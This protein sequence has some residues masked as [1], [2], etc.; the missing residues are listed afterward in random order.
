[1]KK[2][3]TVFAVATTTL[4]LS[5]ITW[6]DDMGVDAEGDFLHGH[7]AVA[8][9]EGSPYVRAEERSGKVGTDVMSYPQDFESGSPSVAAKP[10]E[11]DHDNHEDTTHAIAHH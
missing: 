3:A 11:A 4:S 5:G 8:A 10:G 7:G 2:Y 6:A 1:M 9:S